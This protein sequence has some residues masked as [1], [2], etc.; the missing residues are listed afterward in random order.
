MLKVLKVLK[1][2]KMIKMIKIT[3]FYFIFLGKGL[4]RTP[5]TMFYPC[6]F[7]A[8]FPH[9]LSHDSGETG[10]PASIGFEFVSR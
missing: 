9:G 1:M 6:F 7:T 8:R 4:V 2:I 3:N 5:T 10:N